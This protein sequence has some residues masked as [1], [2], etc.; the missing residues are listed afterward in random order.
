MIKIEGETIR[1]RHSGK[2][3]LLDN[4]LESNAQ[5]EIGKKKKTGN[6]IIKKKPGQK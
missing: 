6:S 3:S 4:F 1:V 5:N 2:Y